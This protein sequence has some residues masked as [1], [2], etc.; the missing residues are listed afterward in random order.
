MT[1][2]RALGA[3]IQFLGDFESTYGTPPAA[4]GYRKLFIGS[5]DLGAEKPMGYEPLLGQGRDALDPFYEAGDT[6][7]DVRVPIDVEQF[8]WWLKLLFG[9]A[10]TTGSADPYS[11]AYTSGGVLPSA[12]LETGHPQLS[13]PR[14][15]RAFGVKAGSLGFEMARR[16]QAN[17]TIGL[18]GQGETRHTTAVDA[19]PT[20][21]GLT[22]FNRSRGVIRM[23]GALLGN[24]IGCQFN[25]SNNLDAAEPIRADGLIDGADE[26]EATANG[27]VTVRLSADT[28]ISAA[29]DAETPLSMET[30]FDRAGSP[31]RSITFATPR[32]FFSRPRERISGPGGIELTYDWRAAKDA[33]AGYLLRA[34]LVNNLAGTSY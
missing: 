3:D 11:H 34:T 1:K 9:A 14:Y 15:K 2:P 18:I 19:S 17:A 30:A 29:V 25:F 7:G 13:T 21:Y 22:Q 27:T 23:G 16:G 5:T 10:T 32:V 4:G 33:T 12:T 31:E 6:R 8:G 28:T 24:I 26:G 20:S